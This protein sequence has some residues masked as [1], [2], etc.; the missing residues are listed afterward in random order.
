MSRK[1]TLDKGEKKTEAPTS[2]GRKKRPMSP[3]KGKEKAGR[4]GRRQNSSRR[5]KKKHGFE[6]EEKEKRKK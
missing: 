1:K 6:K 4:G 2:F 3:V 5:K